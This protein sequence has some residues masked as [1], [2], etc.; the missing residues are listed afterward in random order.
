MLLPC[1]YLCDESGEQNREKKITHQLKRRTTRGE[2]NDEGRDGQ[3]TESDE[4]EEE[5]SFTPAALNRENLILS[6][7]EV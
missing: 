3:F 2:K 7:N 1:P 5:L 6:D 4:E